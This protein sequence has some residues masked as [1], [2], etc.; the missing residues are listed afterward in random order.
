MYII[1]LSGVLCTQRF[2]NLD[3]WE[4]MIAKPGIDRKVKSSVKSHDHGQKKNSHRQSPY[5]PFGADHHSGARS[6]TKRKK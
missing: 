3:A 2:L 4:R 6:P 5:F 1:F